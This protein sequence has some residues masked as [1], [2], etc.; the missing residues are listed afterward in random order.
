VHKIK[1]KVEMYQILEKYIML[2]ESGTGPGE[3]GSG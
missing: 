3:G 2:E 1:A